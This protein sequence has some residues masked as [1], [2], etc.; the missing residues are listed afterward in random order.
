MEVNA[1]RYWQLFKNGFKD[2]PK[3]F[4]GNFLKGQLF[5]VPYYG[6]KLAKF[7]FFINLFAAF[8]KLWN[9]LWDWPTG[10][11]SD[12]PP[13]IR[14]RPHMVFGHDPITGNVLYFDGVG[15]LLDIMEWFGQTDTFFPF[16]KDAKDIL[17]GRQTFG[18]FTAKLGSSVYNKIINSLSPLRKWP[19]EIG[20][21]RTKLLSQC[22]KSTTYQR[23][24]EIHSSI[25][26]TSMAI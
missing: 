25:F 6:W 19:L 12:L 8:V 16:F 11:E 1:K 20:S 26:R 9:A 10:A 23:Y 17:N 24:L 5:N 15:S 18:D 4:M 2:S 21:V 13:D 7:Y 14:E 22:Y 3:D